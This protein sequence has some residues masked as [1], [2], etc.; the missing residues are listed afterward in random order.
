V[1]AST[2]NEQGDIL[3]FGYENKSVNTRSAYI[4]FE[5]DIPAGSEI[6]SATVNFVSNQ[7]DFTGPF[8]KVKILGLSPGVYSSEVTDLVDNRLAMDCSLGTLGTGLPAI[9]YDF[10]NTLDSW[11]AL[12]GFAQPTLSTNPTYMTATQVPGGSIS[13]ERS[14][15]GLTSAASNTKML[16]K[17][18]LVD[19]GSNNTFSGLISWKRTTDSFFPSGA[20]IT[21][22]PVEGVWNEILIDLSPNL[23]WNGTISDLRIQWISS[24]G[25]TGLSAVVDI[26]SI[27]IGDPSSAFSSFTSAE[28][29]SASTFG[30]NCYDGSSSHFQ[31]LNKV[32]AVDSVL[33]SVTIR[34]RADGLDESKT[35]WA[36]I[37][38]VASESPG[39]YRPG[40]LLATS[41]H[42][43]WNDLPQTAADYQFF[44]SNEQRLD[45]VASGPTWM[46]RLNQSFTPYNIAE[47]YSGYFFTTYWGSA[48]TGYPDSTTT[49]TALVDSL[50]NLPVLGITSGSGFADTAGYAYVESELVKFESLTASTVTILER[51]VG[52]TVIAS[53]SI[54][55]AFKVEFPGVYNGLRDGTFTGFTK[56]IYPAG[57]HL[58]VLGTL[59]TETEFVAPGTA[60]GVAY[61]WGSASMSPDYTTD[62]VRDAVFAVVNDEGYNGQIGIK[63]E[64]IDDGAT[65]SFARFKAWRSSNHASSP[66]PSLTVK[67]LDKGTIDGGIGSLAVV[68]GL[69]DGSS[70]I[71]SGISSGSVIDGA[72]IIL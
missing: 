48:G 11:A 27:Q 37:W 50:D 22:A 4:N 34:L 26:D 51:A 65:T 32:S 10:N 3:Y 64:G 72:L 23:T 55:A 57:E 70:I 20:F 35:A 52:D 63:I 42:V 38:S 49:T 30:I 46:I 69:L 5:T 71:G 12:P 54:G 40:S 25:G 45:W 31:A 24:I 33:D 7:T 59:T 56:N 28:G 16:I 68:G 18:R 47:S 13:L 44:F 19:L 1:A 6:E 14:S 39:N 41:N 17:Y 21:P 2:N 60:A 29:G 61:S 15:V 8:N 62:H 58:N 67:W 66:G 43:A 36:E 9:D 53:H